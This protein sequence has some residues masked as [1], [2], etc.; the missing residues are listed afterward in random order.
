MSEGTLATKFQCTHYRMTSNTSDV[1][2]GC[3]K[4]LDFDAATIKGGLLGKG[5]SESAAAKMTD[6]FEEILL[7]QQYQAMMDDTDYYNML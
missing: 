4:V 6:L 3:V 5:H 2:F 7:W 1:S